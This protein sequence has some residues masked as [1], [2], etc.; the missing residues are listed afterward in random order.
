MQ[1]LQ[2][3][4]IVKQSYKEKLRMY[5]KCNK[6]EL[7]KMLIEAN[8]Q[9]K[10]VMEARPLISMFGD[11]KDSNSADSCAT[12][13]TYSEDREKT[14][15]TINNWRQVFGMDRLPD[16]ELNLSKEEYIQIYIESVKDDEGFGPGPD[17]RGFY[18]VS[19]IGYYRTTI[20]GKKNYFIDADSGEQGGLATNIPEEIRK[21]LLSFGLEER[22]NE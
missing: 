17:G 20:K 3:M 18:P 1:N 2:F 15:G 7:A 10:N 8:K 9:L 13:C 19:T 14:R 12:V 16:D 22:S 5:L 11:V 21:I 6:K 4:K